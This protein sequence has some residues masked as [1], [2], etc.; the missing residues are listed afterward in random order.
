MTIFAR[1]S[2]TQMEINM[3]EK[4]QL[5]SFSENFREEEMTESLG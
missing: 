2:V 5:V 3:R 4:K 1:D